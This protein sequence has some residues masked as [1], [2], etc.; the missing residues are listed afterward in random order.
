MAALCSPR[1]SLHATAILALQFS[2]PNHRKDKARLE[3]LN[4]GIHANITLA[5]QGATPTG[6]A[7]GHKC[8]STLAALRRNP[9]R[10]LPLAEKGI[11]A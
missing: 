8:A 5:P 4:F 10:I 6:I 2:N 7:Q 11:G 9:V 3:K 1:R